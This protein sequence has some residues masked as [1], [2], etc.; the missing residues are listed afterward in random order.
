[1]INLKTKMLNRIFQIQRGI[2]FC[3]CFG[4]TSL[5]MLADDSLDYFERRILRLESICI[6]GG[7][8]RAHSA[9]TISNRYRQIESKFAEIQVKVPELQGVIEKLSKVAPILDVRKRSLN[10][11]SAKVNELTLQKE[12]ILDQITSLQ[13]IQS[14][15]HLINKENFAGSNSILSVVSSTFLNS[16]FPC[17]C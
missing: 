10:E 11:T 14:L 2:K 7:Q 17:R 8:G 1:M 5:E 9:E 13:T 3:F 4:D 15:Q 6:H 16:C 12:V